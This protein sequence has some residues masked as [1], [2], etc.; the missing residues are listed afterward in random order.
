MGARDPEQHRLRLDVL[1]VI[2]LGGVIGATARYALSQAVPTPDNGFPIATLA[3]NVI[4]SFLL[5]FVA[6]LGVRRLVSM[7]YF[8]PFV[9][10]GMIGSF[11]TFSAFAV[12]NVELVDRGEIL[13][14]VVYVPIMLSTGLAA[15]RL[16]IGA[17][18]RFNG[19]V[20]A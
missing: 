15:A 7:R 20:R 3:T 10:I 5:G 13:V 2:A 4:G 8:R 12:E 14:A 17:G 19:A 9:A 6:V 1:L 16:G 18:R 11:T